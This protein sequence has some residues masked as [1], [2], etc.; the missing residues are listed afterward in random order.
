MIHCDFQ[1]KH[2]SKCSLAQFNKIANAT[3]L[4]RIA[5]ELGALEGL[6]DSIEVENSRLMVEQVET[7]IRACKEEYQPYLMKSTMCFDEPKEALPYYAPSTYYKKRLEACDEFMD[8][9]HHSFSRLI[10]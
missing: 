6:R 3:R 5:V 10:S 7:L 4:C 8:I 9:Y 1:E 2:N